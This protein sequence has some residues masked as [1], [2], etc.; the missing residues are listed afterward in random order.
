MRE[1]FTASVFGLILIATGGNAIGQDKEKDLT[2]NAQKV[3]I[4]AK[5]KGELIGFYFKPGGIVNG[6]FLNNPRYCVTGPKMTISSATLTGN[7]LRVEFS[8]DDDGQGLQLLNLD[9]VVKVGHKPAGKAEFEET[10]V[11]ANDQTETFDKGT[12]VLVFEDYTGLHKAVPK[13]K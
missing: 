4:P 8:V 13:K 1:L 2:R 11:T 6:A 12:L 9:G 3:M 5:A 10:K 7:K